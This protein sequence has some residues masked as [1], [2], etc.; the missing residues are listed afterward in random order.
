VGD[1][2]AFASP[3][4]PVAEGRCTECHDPH[5]SEM[6]SL[7]A[8]PSSMV[9]G[10]CHGDVV[11][12]DGAES[13]HGPAE[14]DC[15]QC[16]LPH[17]GQ[18]KDMLVEPAPALCFNCH[19]DKGA[20]FQASHLRLDASAMD[21]SSCHAPHSS[22][23][24]SL[25]LAKAHTPFEDDD[26]SVCHDELASGTSTEE[27]CL[28][29]HDV[30][31]GTS[32]SRHAPFA[33][34]SCTECHNPHVSEGENLLPAT[35]AEA[36]FRC[37]DGASLYTELDLAHGPVRD[38]QCELC[39]ESHQSK[40][41]SLL[42]ASNK[43]LCFG[44]H[45]ATGE[46]T[47]LRNQHAPFGQGRCARCHEPHGGAE[48]TMTEQVPSLC[49]GCHDVEKASTV[50]K[51]RGMPVAG[52]DCIGCHAPH[53]S[54]GRGLVH[55]IVHVP[56]AD[57]D[58]SDCHGSTREVSVSDEKK[59]CIGCHPGIGEDVKTVALHQPLEGERPCSVCHEPHAASGTS[60]V[61]ADRDGLCASCHPGQ[62]ES[63]KSSVYSHPAQSVGTCTICHDPHFTADDRG[64]R[65]VDRVCGTCHSS[66]EHVAHPMGEGVPDPR[67]DGF[68]RCVSCHSPHGSDHEYVLLADPNGPLCIACHTDKIRG[69]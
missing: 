47:S 12:F 43:E 34:G 36:C 56:Y 53:A 54:D 33:D 30:S 63:L 61:P 14:G 17:G 37:H 27:L 35:S 42:R 44:C 60:L 52:A 67:G 66:R 39:H 55:E 23:R 62:A 1:P 25:L 9:C 64:R 48:G 15:L 19:D 49:L 13:I 29:C 41:A 40:H 51:H 45:G 31:T 6:P 38:G 28:T 21:C 69:R 4:E 8:G 59:L 26:C 18:G 46:H 22:S 68:V 58:C 20:D 65:K 2:R 57:G 10:G 50:Q 16:H 7:L 32:K 5:R 3:H 24:A 11:E